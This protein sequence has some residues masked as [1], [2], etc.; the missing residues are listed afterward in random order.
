MHFF[1]EKNEE[2]LNLVLKQMTL[3]RAYVLLRFKEVLNFLHTGGCLLRNIFNIGL[4][5]QCCFLKYT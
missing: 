3:S 4:Q 1:Y 5:P 2:I